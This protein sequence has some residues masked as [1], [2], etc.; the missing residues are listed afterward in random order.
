MYL[1]SLTLKGFKSFANTVH[2]SLEP[3][4]TCVVG[5]NGSGKS[6]VVDALAWVMGEQGAKNLRGGQMSDVIFAGT[7]TKAPLG[8]AEVQLTIDNTDGALPIEFAEVTLSRTMFRSGGSEYAINSTPVRLLD[9]QELLSDTGMGRQMHVIVGQGQLDTILSASEQER[10]AFIE[11]AAGVLKHRQ[12]K[13]RALKKL[14]NLAVNLSRVQDLVNEVG[15]RLGPLGKQAEAARKAARVQA[16]LQDASARLLADSVSQYREKAQTQ[17][18]SKGQIEAQIQELNE[19]LA[20]AQAKLGHAKDDF[21]A[22]SPGLEDLTQTWAQLTQVAAHLDSLANQAQE[23]AAALAEAEEVN[24]PADTRE[25]EERLE[26]TCLNIEEKTIAS[27]TA[28]KAVAQ[29]VQ[30]E[31]DAKIREQSVR[32]ELEKVRRSQADRRETLERLRGAVSTAMSLA[33]EATSNLERL[34]RTLAE[35]AKREAES[36]KEL[37]ALSG[38]MPEEPDGGLA[39]EEQKLAAE[40]GTLEAEIEKLNEGLSTAQADAASWAARRDVLAKTLKPPDG[41]QAV[42]DAGLSGVGGTLPEALVVRSGWEE[43]IGAVFGPWAGALLAGNVE[44]GADA[45]RYARNQDVGQVHLLVESG[46]LEAEKAHCSKQDKASEAQLPEGCFWATDLV[47]PHAGSELPNVVRQLLSGVAV[48]EELS[49]ARDLVSAGRVSTAVTRG[50]DFLSSTRMIGGGDPQAGILRRSTEYNEATEEAKTSALEVDL[51]TE[52]LDRARAKLLEIREHHDLVSSQ[53]KAQDAAAAEVA[54]K[55]AGV[56]ARQA[57][58]AA[59]VERARENLA[60]AKE[61]SV[62]RQEI[63]DKAQAALQSESESVDETQTTSRESE[64]NE[65]LREALLAVSEA[66]GAKSDAQ[67]AAHLVQEQL[68]SLQARAESLQ[69]NIAKE[70]AGVEAA[71]ER[72]RQRSRR[73]R[74]SVYVQTQ[75]QAASLLAHT[76]A[77]RA[78]AA[79]REAQSSREDLSE[80]IETLRASVDDLL[81]QRTDLSEASMRDQVVLA[82]VQ[83]H[84]DRL[85][86]QAQTECSL[87]EET[88]LAQFGPHNLVPIFD[89]AG[90]TVEHHPYVREEQVER[91]AKA[92]RELKH[93]GKVNPLALQEH[94][95]LVARHKFL[96]DQ[97]A[98]LKKSRDDLLDV[99]A[100]VDRQVKEVFSTAFSDVAAAFEEI[101]SVLF[102]GGEGRLELS[103]PKDLLNTGIDIHARPAGK[104]VKRMS[105]LSGGERS[106]AALA[107]LF[108]IF[109]ARPSPFYVLDEVEAALDDTNLSRLLSVFEILRKKSQLI[110]I[111]HHKRTMEIADALYGVTMREGTTTV[112]SQRLALPDSRQ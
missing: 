67:I 94:E 93:L 29:A 51:A 15:K 46:S 34:E 100:E 57:A 82:E 44:S 36:S 84:L 60:K 62:T 16:E 5:P 70:K 98:D 13:D 92:L 110:I 43:A 81:R 111:T 39:G 1:K 53:L 2:I 103:D 63:L 35:A 99:V 17:N 64:I 91:K 61:E 20:Q 12:R 25:L 54:A 31:N 33:E 106:L 86:E 24:A 69:R 28:Q 52:S 85:L 7:K 38:S 42:C 14:E 95:A 104:N 76:A 87:E 32:E 72:A 66:Q 50:G 3:G 47:E 77:T 11:E 68:K 22:V 88:L 71:K 105:L 89:E 23:R 80:Q 41:A 56:K 19:K 40:I 45:I 6:N 102:P 97:L 59:E 90:Q 109:Q 108:A 107:F 18:A 37:A 65:E 10:R 74:R 9:I 75:A 96:S 79:R 101:F 78:E 8:R 112:I 83:S 4:V 58:A 27:E 26:R 48:C 49:V 73:R 30:A 55:I 21:D